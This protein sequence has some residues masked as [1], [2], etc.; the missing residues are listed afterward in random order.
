MSDSNMTARST[1]P[2]RLPWPHLLAYMDAALDTAPRT[3]VVLRTY[4]GQPMTLKDAEIMR[5]SISKIRTRIRGRNSALVSPYDALV[6]RAVPD[7]TA[8]TL[9]VHYIDEE[10]PTQEPIPVPSS[11]L[12]GL[13]QYQRACPCF[14]TL[15]RPDGF[16]LSVG[17]A[18]SPAPSFTEAFRTARP[19]LPGKLVL[20]NAYA[21]EEGKDYELEG[22][23]AAP[24]QDEA[25]S[26]IFSDYEVE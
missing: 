24:P 7:F 19:F 12:S 2:P 11:A 21:I 4:A 10:G 17:S 26:S 8:C 6:I 16:S 25:V 5:Q 13:T 22:N 9:S 20:T 1:P 23:G 14:L 15:S 18:D 3:S